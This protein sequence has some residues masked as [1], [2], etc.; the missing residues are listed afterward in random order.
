MDAL[1]GFISIGE[2]NSR[3]KTR[4]LPIKADI[5]RV[6]CYPGGSTL[7]VSQNKKDLMNFVDSSKYVSLGS[8]S[9]SH[10]KSPSNAPSE[11]P[12]LREIM[13]SDTSKFESLSNLDI[14]PDSHQMKGSQLQKLM[15][16]GCSIDGQK[17]EG[18]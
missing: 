5:R 12:G 2:V 11:T 18:M 17:A 10:A 9:K 3:G 16:D 6:L 7:M 8:S 14:I 13:N 4:R 15:N 1:Q